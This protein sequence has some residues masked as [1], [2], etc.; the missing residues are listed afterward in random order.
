MVAARGNVLILAFV[1]AGCRELLEL[2]TGV[3][4]DAVPGDVASDGGLQTDAAF[5]KLLTIKAG[6]DELL[7]DIPVPVVLQRDD[8]LALHARPDARDLHF[9]MNGE[10][11]AHEIVSFDGNNGALEAWVRV[12]TLDDLVVIELRYGGT[13]RADVASATWSDVFAGVWHLTPDVD[14]NYAD[15]TANQSSGVA[16]NNMRPAASEGIAG[17]GATYDGL[18]DSIG[19]GDPVT[20]VLDFATTSFA[21]S[22]W[23]RVTMPVGLFDTVLSK[24]GSNAAPGYDLELGQGAWTAGLSDGAADVL[25]SFGEGD[26]LSDRWVQLAV[27][28]DRPNSALRTYVD[29]QLAT[30]ATIPVGFGSVNASAPLELGQSTNQYRGVL[31]EVRIYNTSRSPAWFQVEH[32]LL[33]APQDTLSIGPQQAL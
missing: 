31:D 4:V 10:I 1:L 24:G 32:R 26:G 9:V 22:A 8:D 5:R 23:V 6:A 33:A 20:G 18:N 25:A 14:L 13:E 16:D 11:L 15:S 2:E 29:G 3:V 21:I 28:V 19:V 27:V 17:M 7:Y 12:P 30:S